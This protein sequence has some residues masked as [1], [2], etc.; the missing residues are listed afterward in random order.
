MAAVINTNYLSLVAQ[1][2]LNKSQS[3]LGTAIERLSSGLRINSAKD[4]AAG[5]AIANRFTANV[6]GLTQAA[7]NANDGISLAQTTEGAASEV[8]THLQRIRELTVQASNG[9]YSQE[10]LDSVQGEINQRLADIDRIS[11]QTDFNGVKVLSD[12]AKPLT[13]QVGAND[14]ETIT[15]NLSEISVKTLGLDGFNVNGKGVTQNRSATVTDVIAQGGT[16]QGDGT[17]K[18]TTTFNAASAE[19]VLSKLEDGNTVAVGGGATYTY[20][21]AKGNFTYTKTVDTTVGA[22]VTALAN[23][24]KPS[25]GTISG[26]YEISTG[27]SASFDVDAAGKITIGGN[28][29]FLNAD[30]ELTT[31]DASGALTQATLDDVLTSVGTE[32]NSSVTIGGTKYSHSAADEL[33]YT[34]VATTADVLSAMGSSTAVSTVTLGSGITSAAVT[35]AIATTDSNNTWVDNKGELTDIQTF[36]TSYKINADTGEVTVVGDNSATAGQYAS[37]DGAKVLVGSDGKLT[38][39]TTSAGDKTTDPLKTLDA[40]FTKLDKLTGELGAVQNRLEST[41]ANLNNVVNNLSSAR[42]RIQDADYATEVSNMSK[43]QILQQAGTSVLAQ[44]NQV[45]QTVLS[46]LR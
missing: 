25:S 13:L 3:S 40:A 26:S 42:S 30:G 10:Q 21:A 12:S 41:I 7:R 24:I 39:E 8:N 16:L 14:G 31:N 32:A 4:D 43:A 44:A 6:R 37:A 27:K 17:Y 36:D 1:N 23:K 5:M 45:P 33:S 29:A 28:A 18:A 34:A 15:L 20:D 46:L 38:T 19:T 22:D 11:E 9:S 35:F 2:N